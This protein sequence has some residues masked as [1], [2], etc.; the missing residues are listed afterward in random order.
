MLQ[1]YR[2]STANKLLNEYKDI[3]LSSKFGEKWVGRKSE[4]W[5]Y[6]N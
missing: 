1:E 2:L 4:G 3:D 6:Y 5:Q